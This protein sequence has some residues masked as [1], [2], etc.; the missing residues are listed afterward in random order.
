MVVEL[1]A[2]TVVLVVIATGT[3]TLSGHPALMIVLGAVLAGLVLLITHGHVV[4]RRM[5]GRRAPVTAG[6]VVTDVAPADPVATVPLDGRTAAAVAFGVAGLFL[7][8]IVFGPVAIGLGLAALRRGA[9]GRWG[10]P[11]ALTAVVLGIADLLVLV[12]LIASR[13]HGGGFTWHS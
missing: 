5:V 3:A 1:L 4:R 8:N 9:P 2:G 12:L 6:R 11:A 7:F 13:V 10:R